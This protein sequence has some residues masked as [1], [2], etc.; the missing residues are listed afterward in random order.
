MDRRAV[1]TCSV[2]GRPALVLGSSQPEAVADHGALAGTGTALVRRAS[3]GGAVV[4]APGSQVWIDAWV[5]RQDRWWDDD[6]ISGAQWL[7]DAWAEGLR[8][9]GLSDVSVHR[10]RAVHSSWSGVVCFAGLGPGE[11]SVGRHKV[12]G[13]AQRRTRQGARLHSMA[14]LHWDPSTVLELLALGGH[15]RLRGAHDVADS[16]AGLADVLHELGGAAADDV[17]RKVE[18]AVLASLPDGE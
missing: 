11:V 3:G 4:V 2:R 12:V 14:L 13:V 18:E 16:A 6:I 7:G 17:L 1:A 9:L 5:P 8:H 10:G 15:D